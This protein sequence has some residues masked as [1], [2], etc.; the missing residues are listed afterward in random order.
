M[1]FWFL[2]TKTDLYSVPICHTYLLIFCFNSFATYSCHPLPLLEVNL[3]CLS[4][5][6]KSCSPMAFLVLLLTRIIQLTSWVFLCHLSWLN[7]L[8]QKPVISYNEISVCSLGSK[9]F[10][11]ALPCSRLFMLSFQFRMC[12][13][14]LQLLN[15]M[16]QRPFCM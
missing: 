6:G 15:S 1:V 13:E 10:F 14:I 9:S 3:G 11:R 5:F 8:L 12:L 16:S 7:T 2:T 4:P